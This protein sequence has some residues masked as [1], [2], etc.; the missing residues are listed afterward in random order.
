MKFKDFWEVIPIFPLTAL[1]FYITIVILWNIGVIPP[2][3]ELVPILEGWY[4]DFGLIGVFITSFLEGLAYI[5][6][7]IPG[8]TILFL[9][10]IFSDGSFLS[11]LFISLVITL[12]LTIV[13]I[14]NYFMGMYFGNKRKKELKK[15]GVEKSLFLSVI[16]PNLLAFYFFNRGLKK[17]EFWKVFLIPLILVPY[18]LIIAYIISLSSDFFKENVVGNPLVFLSAL[19]LWFLVALVLENREYFGKGIHRIYKHL[20]H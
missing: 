14:V 5:G 6:L 15:H 8:T 1:L 19:V 17:K 2:P 13:S 16:H 11:L 20:F 10:V 3:R 7:Y 9:A 18:A 4:N 12:S